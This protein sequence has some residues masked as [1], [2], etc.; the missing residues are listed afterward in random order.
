[1]EE[2]EAHRGGGGLERRRHLQRRN[3]LVKIE[4]VSREGLQEEGDLQR[5]G[6]TAK[7]EDACRGRDLQRRR[8]HMEEAFR[9]LKGLRRSRRM[10]DGNNFWGW[11]SVQYL[12]CA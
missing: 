7:E 8:R 3:M 9:G 6:W 12:N 5:R 11:I 10:L 1:L 4:E 2:R